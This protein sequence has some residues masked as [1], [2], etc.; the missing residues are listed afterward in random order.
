MGEHSQYDQR[1]TPCPVGAPNHRGDDEEAESN[2]GNSHSRPPEDELL[3]ARHVKRAFTA[4]RLAAERLAL[5]S[6]PYFW[7]RGGSFICPC[8]ALATKKPSHISVTATVPDP[9]AVTS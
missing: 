2:L 5:S 8:R 9:A 7:R 1:Q 6:L 4:P 3:H